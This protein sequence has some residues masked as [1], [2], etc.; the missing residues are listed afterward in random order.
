LKFKNAASV[1][2][3]V[4]DMKISDLPRSGNRALINSLFNGEAPYTPEEQARNRIKT[5]CN[6]LDATRL[7]H[8]ARRQFSQAFMKPGNYFT[9]KVDRGSVHDR[10]IWSEIITKEI[11][12]QLKKSRQYSETLR[13]VFA[14]LVIHGVGGVTWPDKQSWCPTMH[15]MGDILVPSRTLRSMENL[16]YFAIYRRYTAAEL[17]EKTH[18]PRV[19]KGWKMEIVNKAIK[20]AM[21]QRGQ[22]QGGNDATWSPE[23]W[24]EDVKSDSGLY[25]SDQVPTIDTWD[26]YFKQEDAKEFGWKRRIVLDTPSSSAVGAGTKNIL[27]GRNE[28]LFDPGDRN[29]AS[30]L[31]EIVHFQF[32]DGSVVAPFRYHSVRSLG[33]LLYCVCHLQNRLRCKF[34]DSVFESLLQYFRVSNPEDAARLQ[35]VDLHDLGI[36]PDGLN[37]VKQEERWAVKEG[38][39]NAAMN[40]NRQSMAEHSTSFNQDFG[41]D[42]ASQKQDKTATQIAAEVNASNALVGSMLEE[43]YDYQNPQYQEICRRFCIPK[44][45]SMAVKN[46]RK[47]CLQQGVPESILDSECWNVSPERTIGN[48]NKTIELAQVNLLMQHIDRYDPDSQRIILRRYTFAACDDPALADEL[49]PIEKN[50]VTDSVHDAQL[51]AATLLL[52]LPMGLKQGIN[53]GEYAATLLG[54]MN[55]EIQKINGSGG[56]GTADQ[57]AGLQN[58]AGQSIEGQPIEGNGVMNHINILAQ[59]ESKK[60]IVKQLSDMLGKLMNEVKAF[61]QRLQEQQASQNGNGELPPEVAAK[62]KGEIISA[63]AKAEIKKQEGQLKLEQKDQQFNQKLQ[64]EQAR[65]E[66]DMA[67]RIREVEVN[68]IAADLKGAAAIRRQAEPENA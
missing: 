20:W 34:N 44:S 27:E 43:A 3:V 10:A 24:V 57:I 25:A 8:D 36:I 17:Y 52:A 28:F 30:A 4:W 53:H 54:M 55:S 61:A 46:F 26:F 33:F 1:E 37:F 18:G 12:K 9:V 31:S 63:E 60:A 66:L 68:E 5:N 56:V 2:S 21:K 62:L 6:F 48:G 14:Q 47:A 23:K 29:Y 45:Q 42:P 65:H 32:A 51:A 35:K 64:Q 22:T 40:L 67:S 41:L 59:D 11:N 39:I 50:M 19:D 7:A 58:L 13:N 16:S 15:M 49:V 38:L